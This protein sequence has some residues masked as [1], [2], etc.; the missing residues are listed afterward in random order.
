V[1]IDNGVSRR[2]LL[3]ASA[4]GLGVMLAGGTSALAKPLVRA[5]LAHDAAA[6]SLSVGFQATLT[7]LTPVAIQGYQWS[8]M[9]G[10]AIY[11]PLFWRAKNGSLI[12]ALATSVSYPKPTKTVLK[13]RQGV[14]FHDGTPLTAQDVA[15]SIGVRCDPAMIKT[16]SGRPVMTPAQFG[17]I[18]VQDAETVVVNTKS[19]VDFLYTPQPILIIPNN[20][21]GK[22]NFATAENGTGPFKVT[23]FTSGSKVSMVANPNYWAGKPPLSTLVFSLFADISTEGANL[24]SGEVDAL[25]DVS[26]LHLK[27]VTGVSG[28]KLVQDATYAD[29]WI[30]QFGTPPLNN[31]QVRKALYYCFDK[32]AMNASSFA[33][34]GKT[35]WNPFQ[36]TG[37]YNGV[38][39][40]NSYDPEK[41][42]SLLKAAGATNITVPLTGIQGYQDSI[43]QGAIIQQGLEAAGVKSSFV[44]LP[45]AQWLSE[46]YTKGSWEGIAFNAGNVPYPYKNFFDYMVD[47]STLLS[48]FT[49]GKSPL[50]AIENLYNAVEA[51]P[52][53]SAKEK[54]LLDQAQNAI[55]DQALVYFG[56]AGPVNLVLPQNLQDVIANGLGD[57]LWHKAHF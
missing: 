32:Q 43:N 9:V 3:K 29:W 18:V 21:F 55:V 6:S 40:P 12:P 27:S 25:Y 54:S 46:T 28:K 30:I 37:A 23:S 31:L 26:P 42:K 56:L 14:K 4:G 10:F 17:S 49:G 50:P 45:I 57:V 22:I 5:P 34:L 33:G 20:S 24:R 48:K 19:E 15:Y 7:G 2:T 52:I 44:A 39:G 53:A 1:G 41:A 51:A 8:Q 11:D 35:S 13:I 16:T 38:K 47:P 36:F